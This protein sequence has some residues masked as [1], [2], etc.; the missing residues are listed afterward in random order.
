MKRNWICLYALLAA[1]C[2]TAAKDIA[3][4]Y[5]S[6]QPYQ[7]YN[8]AQVAAE[9]A[10][11]DARAAQ[12]ARR[13]DDA[14]RNDKGIV[15]V[16]ALLFPPALFALGGTAEEEAVYAQLKGEQRALEETAAAKGCGGSFA[17]ASGVAT[18]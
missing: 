16:G 12:L 18:F 3:P 8:C 11:I 7:D 4:S 15:L 10:R 17:S 9:T 6:P 14:A 1:G 13:L 2:S 5:A